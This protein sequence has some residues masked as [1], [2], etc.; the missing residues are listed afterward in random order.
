MAVSR[1]IEEFF[2]RSESLPD[3][4]GPLSSNL[5]SSCITAAN[6]AVQEVQKQQREPKSRGTY[7]KLSDDQKAEIARYA[8]QNGNNV[9]VKYYSKKLEKPIKE[10]SVRTWIIKYK[11]EY[12]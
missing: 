5:S 8:L 1:S 2:K 7:V 12:Q 3:P 4:K 6:K 11:S 10:S 9:A